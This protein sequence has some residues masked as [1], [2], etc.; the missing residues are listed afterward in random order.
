M[1]RDGTGRIWRAGRGHLPT[2]VRPSRPPFHRSSTPAS[3]D[4]GTRASQRRLF[5]AQPTV[6]TRPTRRV[7]G[8]IGARFAES[9]RA[10]GIATTDGELREWFA[11]RRRTNHFRVERIPLAG[12][13]GW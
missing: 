10:P 8:S 11:D 4:A 3:D 2:P 1:P 12:L 7:A 13:E 6:L 9:A 5:M